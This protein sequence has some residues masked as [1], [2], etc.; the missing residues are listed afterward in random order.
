V[1]DLHCEA[2]S[3]RQGVGFFCDGRASLVGWVERQLYP[4]NSFW[5]VDG[6]RRAQPILRAANIGEETVKRVPATLGAALFV[7]SAA[8]AANGTNDYLLSVTP[9]IPA[10][11]PL[12]C[13]TRLGKNGG[14]FREQPVR[15]DL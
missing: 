10:D 1:V 5:D 14:L 15:F 13:P 3:E 8:N 12:I 4:S 11:T 2:A 7:V 9:Q 6:F